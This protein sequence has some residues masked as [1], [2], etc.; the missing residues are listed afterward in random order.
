MFEAIA[1]G[2][3]VVLR[4]FTESDLNSY[5]RWQTLGEWRY[6]DASWEGIAETLSAEQYQEL[7][8][9]FLQERRETPP[10]LRKSLCIA[11][12]DETPIGWVNRYQNDRLPEVYFLGIDICEDAY[13][14]QG[15]GTEA[16]KLWVDYLFSNSDIHKLGLDTWS[17]NPRMMH[18]A[19]KAGFVYE[20]MEREVR[21]WQSDRISLVHYGILRDEWDSNPK[22][23]RG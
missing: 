4:D 10:A 9:H 20:G 1:I 18:S 2:K 15:L 13:L 7:S 5:L 14:G 8:K 11:A 12:L 16:L 21:L 22:S 19:E 23:G 17:I 3:M 6:F